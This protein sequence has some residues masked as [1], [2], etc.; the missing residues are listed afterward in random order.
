M[1][2]NPNLKIILAV[3]LNIM[4]AKYQ[5]KFLQRDIVCLHKHTNKSGFISPQKQ[6]AVTGGMEEEECDKVP[7]AEN[8]Y[9]MQGSFEIISNF[10]VAPGASGTK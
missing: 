2:S 3:T 1:K 7:K 10:I 9:L 6:G 4:G 5:H 8:S